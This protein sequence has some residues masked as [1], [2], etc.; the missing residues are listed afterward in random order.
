MLRCYYDIVHRNNRGVNHI[1]QSQ[2]KKII[3]RRD[4]HILPILSGKKVYVHNGLTFSALKIETDMLG[5]IIGEYVHT[6]QR[7]VYKR[8]KNKKKKKRKK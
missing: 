7:C 1:G 2:V 4:E 3:V 8:R 6:K 5:N